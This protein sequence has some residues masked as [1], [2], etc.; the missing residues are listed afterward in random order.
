MGTK[1]QVITKYIGTEEHVGFEFTFEPVEGS[2]TIEQTK[3]GYTARYIAQ[4]DSSENPGEWSDNNLFL[5]GYHRDFWVEGPRVYRKLPEGQKRDPQDKGHLLVDKEDAKA[6][7]YGNKKD[8]EANGYEWPGELA[9]GYYTFPLEAYIHSGVKLYLSG[10]CAV[11]R[12]WDVSQ[13]G[14]VFVARSEWKTRAKAEKAARG[15]IETW[16]QY[17][18]GDVYIIVREDYDSKKQHINYD[19]V[20]GYYG[21]DYALKAAQTDI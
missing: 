18:S 3:T 10:G 12:A 14:L 13:L 20:G 4:D 9:K 16:N 15:L 11:D 6:L 19:C 1:K 17:L 7:F 8:A 5:V 2:I 21:Y